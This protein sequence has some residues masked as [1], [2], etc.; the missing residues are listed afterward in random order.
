MLA[1]S[2]LKDTSR[3]EN[4]GEVERFDLPDFGDGTLLDIIDFDDLFIGIDD[5]DVLPDLE[6]DPEILA[7]ISAS[8]GEESEIN[9]SLSAEKLDGIA[10]GS[11]SA[12]SGLNSSWT[13]A[14]GED[15]EILSKREE[16]VASSSNN[17]SQKQGDK[18]RK[19]STTTTAQSKNSQGKRKV[20]VI[21]SS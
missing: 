1:V 8:G 16:R 13:S 21:N 2:P 7:D 3:D 18:G 17:T 5:E 20:K 11:G 15:R 4:Q 14:P 10:S 6:M 12:G 19:S 9:T